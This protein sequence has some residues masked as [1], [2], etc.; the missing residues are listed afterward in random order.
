VYEESYVYLLAWKSRNQVLLDVSGRHKGRDN[1]FRGN[2]EAQMPL[3]LE[4]SR[5]TYQ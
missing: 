3:V 1:G 4:T 5:Q 2:R